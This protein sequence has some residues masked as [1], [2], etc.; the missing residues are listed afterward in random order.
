MKKK[1]SRRKRRCHSLF[2]FHRKKNKECLGNNSRTPL[3]RGDYFLK[4]R[5]ERTCLSILNQSPPD[6][7]SKEGRATVRKV[8]YYILPV[9]LSRLSYLNDR[10]ILQ[11]IEEYYYD[12]LNIIRL[13]KRGLTRANRLPLDLRLFTSAERVSLSKQ[14]S[15]EPC[16]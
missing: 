4:F 15:I 8:Y 3:L 14:S 9:L 6:L 13:N 2:S 12:A 16:Q 1:P 10:L 11:D 5:Q 7:T